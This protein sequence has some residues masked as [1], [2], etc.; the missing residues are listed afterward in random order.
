[1]AR[2]QNAPDPSTRASQPQTPARANRSGGRASKRH[3]RRDSLP[4]ISLELKGP[5]NSI[6][7]ASQAV[8]KA[9]TGT[10]SRKQE[11]MLRIITEESS[12]LVCLIE[13][14]L[15]M[16]EIESGKLALK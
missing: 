9:R 3:R 16:A 12:A 7:S 8:T 2:S 11:K 13:D 5:L 15:D 10:I 4:S 14:L 6:R 1:M